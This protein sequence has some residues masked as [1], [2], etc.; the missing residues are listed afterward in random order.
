MSTVGSA[1]TTAFAFNVAGVK[2]ELR[3]VRFHGHERL[4]TPFQFEIEL[5]SDDGAIDF[6]AILQ[7]KATLSL[8]REGNSRKFA[9]IVREFEQLDKQPGSV[10]YRAILVPKLW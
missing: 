8:N 7:G 9:G 4:S 3:V 1:Q 5:A 2:S 6:D 10:R